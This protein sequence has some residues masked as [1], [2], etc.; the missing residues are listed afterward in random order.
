MV[1]NDIR[2]FFERNRGV[3]TNPRIAYSDTWRRQ[4]DYV[5][6]TIFC[7]PST[8]TRMSFESA[9]K[10][11]GGSSIDFGS[12]AISS[13]AKGESW[14]DTAEVVSQ[15]CDVLC[16]RTHLDELPRIFSEH[17][18]VPVINCGSG[19]DEHPTQA[20]LDLYTIKR[21]KG[22]IGG[23]NVVIYG[24]VENARTI[25]SLKQV[26]SLYPVE[27][28]EIDFMKGRMDS[29]DKYVE[30]F[31]K[32]DVVYITRM[33]REWH[34]EMVAEFSNL[35]TH[36]FTKKALNLLKDDAIILHP[37]PVTDEVDY[38][39][40]KDP[41]WVYKQQIKNGLYVRMALLKLVL[42]HY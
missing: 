7:Q 26:L 11:L 16:V 13:V 38:E 33:Q 20:L 24:D 19:R 21:L 10:N 1:D 6:G 36:R 39:V 42:G 22:E 40:R 25:N 8:R 23:L 31:Q 4:F 30:I 27:I 9:V 34:G 37:G 28:V 41:R 18:D 2:P 15:Y 35:T 12:E 29:L 32:A 14:Q 3:Y 17:S 5:M